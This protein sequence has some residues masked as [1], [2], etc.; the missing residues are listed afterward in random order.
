MGWPG[1]TFGRTLAA[2]QIYDHAV[3]GGWYQVCPAGGAVAKELGPTIKR[4]HTYNDHQACMAPSETLAGQRAAMAAKAA[5]RNASVAGRR[6][7]LVARSKRALLWPP[8][9]GA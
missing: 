9:G 2:L 3:D 7:D 4:I 8:F 6:L 5:G 1:T